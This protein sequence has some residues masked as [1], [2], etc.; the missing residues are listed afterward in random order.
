[1]H[2]KSQLEHVRGEIARRML[3]IDMRLNNSQH[4]AERC[5]VE[6]ENVS[7]EAPRSAE[8][9]LRTDANNLV[10]NAVCKLSS[11]RCHSLSL[12]L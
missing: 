12:S 1:M 3:E 5:R 8:L 7:H 4:V 11:S 9:H 6:L 2:H 10:T